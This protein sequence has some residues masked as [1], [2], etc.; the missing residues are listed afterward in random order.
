MWHVWVEKR[1]R[2]GLVEKCVG[3][4]PYRRPRHRRDYNIKTDLKEI[5]CERLDLIALP[6]DTKNWWD[7]V[8]LVM[9]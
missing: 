1:Y 8:N 3:Q 4:R 7:Y 5:V 2:L 6:R 9:N